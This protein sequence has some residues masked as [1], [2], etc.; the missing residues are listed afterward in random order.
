M[1]KEIKYIIITIF[2]DIFFTAKDSVTSV[3]KIKELNTIILF[4]ALVELVVKNYR[5]SILCF[6]LFVLV[7]I[8]T[9]IKE[10]KWKYKMRQDYVK[11][12]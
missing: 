12:E 1:I 5:N 6:I 7:Y 8:Y 3:I 9:I 10:G 2:E 11:T 4:I